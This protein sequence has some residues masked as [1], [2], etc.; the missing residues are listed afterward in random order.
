[1]HYSVTKLTNT[2]GAVVG[3]GYYKVDFSASPFFARGDGLALVDPYG[4]LPVP[5]FTP[6]LDPLVAKVD[7]DFGF[8]VL[9]PWN[10][11]VFS[12]SAEVPPIPEI[13]P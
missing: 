9:G 2:Q 3:D 7:P 8:R 13:C 6:K 4:W 1:V 10:S 12:S 5:N 11:F